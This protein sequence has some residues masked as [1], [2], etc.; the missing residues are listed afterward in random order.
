MLME[1]KNKL[2]EK[3]KYVGTM[4]NLTNHYDDNTS[5]IQTTYL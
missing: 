2:I 4:S 5:M 1:I 3:H